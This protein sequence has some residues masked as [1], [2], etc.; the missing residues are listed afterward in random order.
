M[1]LL[2]ASMLAVFALSAQAAELNIYSVYPEEA[3]GKAIEVFSARTGTKVNLI[4]AKSGEL[5]EKLSSE[6]ANS[7]A[8]LHIDKDL[9]YHAKAK[10]MGLYSEINSEFLNKNIPENFFDTNKTWFMVFYRA[11]VMMYNPKNVKANELSNFQDLADPKWN[12]RLCMRTSKSSY[13]EALTAYFI[14]H[15][16]VESTKSMLEGMVNNLAV[17]PTKNDRAM[18]EM[19]D[20]GICDIGIANTYYL[21]PYI[22]KNPDFNVKV[23]FPNQKNS[24]AHVNGV[25]IGLVKSSKNKKL[26]TQFMEFMASTEVQGP[27]AQAFYQYPVNKEAAVEATISAFGNFKV[28]TTSVDTIGGRI[29]EA[30]KLMDEVEYK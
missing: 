7:P 9:V 18:I 4:V 22:V 12:G 25:G 20:A 19:I 6:G 23:I 11:R 30:R 16:G 27:L 14:Q 1:K 5:L 10:R 13:N 8:D 17:D 24:M 21:A 3:L 15:L 26:A 29:E 28:D 2:I